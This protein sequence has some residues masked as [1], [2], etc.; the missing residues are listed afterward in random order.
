MPLIKPTP[1]I[2]KRFPEAH[3]TNLRLLKVLKFCKLNL[4]LVKLI[5][6]PVSN[7]NL[8]FEDI[9]RDSIFISADKTKSWSGMDQRFLLSGHSYAL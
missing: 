8:D 1:I 2:S 9:L 3:R 6:E 5:V 4:S 7:T